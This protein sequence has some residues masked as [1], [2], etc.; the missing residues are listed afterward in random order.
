MNTPVELLARANG[1]LG[2]D[3]NPDE[4]IL[5]AGQPQVSVKQLLT[6][7][8]PICI[9]NAIILGASF[10]FIWKSATGEG[11]QAI[12]IAMT[13]GCFIIWFLFYFSISNAYKPGK[14]LY[15]LSNQRVFSLFLLDPLLRNYFQSAKGTGYWLTR[16]GEAAV[17]S[18]DVDALP[19]LQEAIRPDGSGSL[20]FCYPGKGQMKLQPAAILLSSHALGGPVFVEIPDARS[21]AEQVKTLVNERSKQDAKESS[22]GRQSDALSISR[23]P[24]EVP[25]ALLLELFTGGTNA[26]WGWAVALFLSFWFWTAATSLIP[27][28]QVD[29][30]ILRWTP[31]QE[32][33]AKI[34]AIDDRN[35]C[36][37]S[38]IDFQSKAG[39]HIRAVLKTED[40]PDQ[41]TIPIE[42]SEFW[43]TLARKAGDKPSERDNL[44]IFFLFPIV[45]VGSIL[46][47]LPVC[48]LRRAFKTIHLLKN[49]NAVYGKAI[50]SDLPYFRVN[51]RVVLSKRNYEYIVNGKRQHFEQ[52]V[53]T[54][55]S[56]KNR[57]VVF[58]DP[59]NTDSAV[60]LGGLPGHPTVSERGKIQISNPGF[61][62][63]FLLLPLAVL[64]INIG[65]LNHAYLAAHKEQAMLQ[66]SMLAH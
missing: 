26:A 45:I 4:K 11:L 30:V 63:L 22:F 7:L 3:L 65:F 23:A 14:V 41:T 16:S 1:L 60:Y 8:M 66:A 19:P 50:A 47:Y 54:E 32:T 21:V 44:H 46:V 5:W 42:Y 59:H 49:G 40:K 17:R 48:I 56:D 13:T 6:L 43:P 58:Y 55:W 28:A 20:A 25:A 33:E 39:S 38:L 37:Y 9:F 52:L 62:A 61:K 12:F 24:R 27:L 34:L 29:K 51:N 64:I 15:A 36:S 18:A 31:V 35:Y 53:E 10:Y 2:Q 57:P